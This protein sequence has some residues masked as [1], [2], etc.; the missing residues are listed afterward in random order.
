MTKIPL[1]GDPSR[2]KY[3]GRRLLERALAVVHFSPVMSIS[4]P[5]GQGVASFQES[6]RAIYP[7]VER[8][9]EMVMRIDVQD[10]GPVNAKPEERIAWRFQD[11]EKL[12][13]IILTQ[14]SLA[15]EANQAGYVSWSDFLDKIGFLIDMVKKNFE[16]SFV[17]RL[18]V[19]YLNAA[20]IEGGAD[21]REYCVKDLVSISG[22]D[23]LKLADLFWSF[24]VDEG[25]L[26]LRCGLMPPSASYDPNFFRSRGSA[27]WYLD[28]DVVH[29]NTEPFDR[30]TIQKMLYNQARRLHAIYYW[31]IP[32]KGKNNDK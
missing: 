18:G 20:P 26:L 12:N 5:S 19:R 13:F 3:E 8:T 14:S 1:R 6:I 4:D 28:I 21:P 15:F 7:S 22:N 32:V 11:Q 27:T 30:D 31:A 23:D 17:E 9:D 24:D 2:P 16:P 25:Q 29:I 10:S